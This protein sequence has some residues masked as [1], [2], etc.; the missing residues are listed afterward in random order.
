MISAQD[1]AYAFIKGQIIDLK[2]KAGQKLR[3]QDLAKK[4]G[5]SRT[6]VR[7]ALSRLEQEGMVVRDG[8][9]GYMVRPITFQE[10]LDLF[11]IRE[12]LDAQAAVAACANLDEKG[13]A[14][15]ETALDKAEAFL[16]NGRLTEFREANREF[17]MLIAAGSGIDLLHRILLM[18]NDR[19]RLV[20]AM[21][22]DIRRGRAPEVLAENRAILGA[23]KRRDPVGV[24]NAVLDHICKSKKEFLEKIRGLRV[25]A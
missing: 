12:L 7:E 19:I 4:L 22:L 16:G 25:V 1:K 17:H 8:G 23:L 5:I 10:I 6:P 24:K 13:V 3:A 11:V 18:T 21:H 20:S 2:I 9:W 15:L 14:A